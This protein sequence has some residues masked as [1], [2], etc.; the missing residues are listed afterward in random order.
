Q[1]LRS[2]DMVYEQMPSLQP[3]SRYCQRRKITAAKIYG[4]YFYLPLFRLIIL[5]NT[6]TATA[7]IAAISTIWAY[8]SK[9]GKAP[10]HVS[11]SV[12]P[13]STSTVFHT[14]LPISVSITNTGMFIFEKPAGSDI[15]LLT[16]GTHLQRS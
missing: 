13:I 7:A 14:A 11:P 15:K 16:S 3:R 6:N 5:Y 8:L 4:S 9:Y 10:V 1:T 12:A 2:A